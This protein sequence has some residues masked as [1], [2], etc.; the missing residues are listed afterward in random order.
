M[1][2]LK[3][4]MAGRSGKM[5]SALVLATIHLSLCGHL[6]AAGEQ[7][8]NSVEGAVEALKTAIAARDTNALHALFGPA[9]QGLVSVDVVEAVNEREQFAVRVAE[10]LVLVKEGDSK[11]VLQLGEDGWAFPIP[12]LQRAGHW[13][14]DTETGREEILNR[15]IGA[16]ELGTIRVCRTYVQAQREYAGFDWHGDG[17]LAYAQRLR[18]TSGTHDGLYWPPKPGE[19]PSPLGP[20]IAQARVEGYRRETR[21]F[22]D[23]KAP[24]HGYY[25]K[26]LTGQG[27]QVPGGRYNYIINGHMI[28]GFALVAWPAQW[29]NSGIMTFVVNQRG[30]VHQ[31]NLGSKT[32]TLAGG[33]TLYN[34]DAGWTLVKD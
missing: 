30:L 7:Q 18:S 22:D 17:V 3:S 26:I 10:R 2:L 23:Q 24:Y 8:F 6:R 4:P 33:M 20:L 32:S 16:N 34:P 19:E 29:G 15:R 11:V 1:N 13:S 5:W 27:A 14:F 21:A 12:L 31:K 28:A 9:G 25:F